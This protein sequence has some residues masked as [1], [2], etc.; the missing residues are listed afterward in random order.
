MTRFLFGPGYDQWLYSTS[1]EL[2]PCW[3]YER[4]ENITCLFLA[5]RIKW[6]KPNKTKPIEKLERFYCYNK[7]KLYG[8]KS[9][10]SSAE[11]DQIDRLGLSAGGPAGKG[12]ML[13]QKVR[14]WSAMQHNAAQSAAISARWRAA[15]SSF[16]HRVHAPCRKASTFKLRFFLIII[17]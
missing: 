9:Q 16:S 12:H 11:L 2:I 13:F 7:R 15:R 1:F 4:N 3:M 8:I 5:P 17:I 6:K 10:Q 14:C